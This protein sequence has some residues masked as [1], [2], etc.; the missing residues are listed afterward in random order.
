MAAHEEIR[1]KAG[2][3][4]ELANLDIFAMVVDPESFDLLLFL[5]G[6]KWK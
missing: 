3:F 5:I 1:N 4:V 2:D 6:I